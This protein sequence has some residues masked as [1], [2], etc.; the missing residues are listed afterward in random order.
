[1]KEKKIFD[2]VTNVPDEL[3]EEAKNTKLRKSYNPKAKWIVLAAC[4]ALIV[5]L[6]SILPKLV[7]KQEGALLDSNEALLDVVFPNAYAFDDHDGW[8]EI[9]ENNPIDEAFIKAINDF[10]YKT[11][12]QILSEQNDNTNYSP[13][14]LYY[15]LALAASGAEGETA[16]ELLALLGMPDQASLSE[17]C[18]NLY[19]RLYIDNN[20]GK[21]QINNSLW[22]DNEIVWKDD[23]IRNAAENFYA[24]S[25]SEDFSDAK[26][27]QLMAEWVS[28]KTN[29]T[30]K[31]EI[32]IDPE[33]I[34]SIINTIYFYDQWINEFDKSKTEED[35][36]YLSDE[37]TISCDFMNSI[38]FTGFSKGNGFTRSSLGLKNRG[39]MVF[40]LPDEGRSPQELLST[41]E[42][43]KEAFD[44]GEEGYGEV[45]WQIPKFNFG[46]SLELIDILQQLGVNA[47]FKEEDADFSG[48]TDNVAFISKIRQETHIAID[49]KGVEASSYTQIDYCGA[50]MP[51]DKADMI[52]NRPFIFGI[53][54]YDGTLLFIG[55]CE[56]PVN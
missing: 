18:G 42:K 30:L 3:V 8:R 14:S 53:A 33:Q 5:G 12:S 22:M 44:G 36:F 16:D 28:E 25:F 1:M 7:N 40:I 43:L 45:T 47:A 24:Y 39:S 2:A 20:I 13:L 38:S 17:Q 55:V 31:P 19:R 34:L 27:A 46:T 21:L 26:T 41:P 49:E 37:S 10:T 15:A 52:L 11:A 29:G 32:K 50:G 4:L 48:I 35:V 51:G 54:A 9:R 56:N 23:F 6:S